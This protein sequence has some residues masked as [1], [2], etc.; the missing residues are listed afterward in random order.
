MQ[1]E[2]EGVAVWAVLIW[3]CGVCERGMELGRLGNAEAGMV[4][5]SWV[6]WS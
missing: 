3:G 5:R 1:W 4:R 6:A 2:G